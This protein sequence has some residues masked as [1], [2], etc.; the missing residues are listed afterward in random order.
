MRWNEWGR[1]WAMMLLK[2][3]YWVYNST[4]F[5]AFLS[6]GTIFATFTAEWLPWTGQSCNQSPSDIHYNTFDKNSWQCWFKDF[7]NFAKIIILVVWLGPGRVL[8]DGYITVIKI[9][10][11]ICKER[12]VKMESF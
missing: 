2:P 8:A 12:R 9:Q 11:E 10:M 5:T 1:L 7:N 4:P 6:K 3:I